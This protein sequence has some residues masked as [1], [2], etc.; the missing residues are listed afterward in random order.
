MYKRT[1]LTASLVLLTLLIAGCGT[2]PNARLYIL[3]AMDRGDSISTKTLEGQSITVKVGPVSVPDTLDQSLI[4]SR[5]GTNRLIT[6]EFNRWGGDFQSDI[7]GII[8]ENISILLPTDQVILS[9]EI[10]LLPIDFQVLV[11]IRE[12]DGVLGGIVTLNADW[13]V[14]SKGKDKTIVTKKSV[15]K[16]QADGTGYDAYVATQ[17][18]LLGEL[19][20]QI[21][22]E[23]RKQLPKGKLH[24]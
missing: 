9:Q 15:L 14:A 5:S 4:V 6:D 13:T 1:L 2:S 22:A 3:N 11:N 12:F 23:I 7:L 10:V 19:S 18:R 16:E 21:T 24:L 17:S 8:G 20:Q